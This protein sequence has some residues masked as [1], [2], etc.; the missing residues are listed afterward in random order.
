[1]PDDDQYY[2]NYKLGKMCSICDTCI[3]IGNENKKAILDGLKSQNYN[4]KNI[5]ICHNLEQAK[6]H[7]ANL[8][9]GDTLLLLNDLPDDYS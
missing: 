4:F 6:T 1:M 2:I 3:I 9:N 7:F 5:I 8:N